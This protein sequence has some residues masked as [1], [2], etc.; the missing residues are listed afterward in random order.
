MWVVK[1]LKAQIIERFSSDHAI[2]IGEQRL[3]NL[4]KIIFFMFVMT[5][6]GRF[7][8]CINLIRWFI[9]YCQIK[10]ETTML[11]EIQIRSINR[12]RLIANESILCIV[13]QILHL[14]K[15]NPKQPHRFYSIFNIFWIVFNMKN[16]K[17]REHWCL[18]YKNK[19]LDCIF[20][21]EV[22]VVLNSCSSRAFKY[23]FLSQ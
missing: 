8:V 13:T 1:R 14:P 3:I 22:I 9:F 15:R 10:L 4:L 19:R 18:F 16:H 7:R 6:K 5:K 21:H 20:V 12:I 23:K 17:K 2:E 11:F